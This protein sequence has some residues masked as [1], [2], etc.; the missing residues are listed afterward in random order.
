MKQAFTSSPVLLMPDSDKPFR[1]ECDASDFAIG[2]VL[3]QQGADNDWHPVAY[4]SHALTATERNY[5]TH[6]KELLAIIRAFEDWRHYLEGS[7]HPVD[8]FTDHKNLEHFTTARK[9]NRRQARWALYLT[10]FDFALYHRPGRHNHAD[11]LSRRADHR[12]GVQNDNTNRVLFLASEVKINA[13]KL[14]SLDDVRQK[15]LDTDSRDAE[16]AEAMRIITEEG[17]AALKRKLVGWEQVDS[18]LTYNGRL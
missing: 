10:R 6:D 4:I 12:E 9:L 8:V 7:P 5:D 13:T 1:V 17:P 11:P 14:V 16:V 2:A 18:L 3:S 15:V